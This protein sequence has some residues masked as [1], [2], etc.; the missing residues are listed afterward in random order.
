[1]AGHLGV[2]DPPISSRRIFCETPFRFSQKQTPRGLKTSAARL[3]LDEGQPSASGW[4]LQLGADMGRDFR[5]VVID[6][7]AKTMMRDAPEFRPV[8]QRANRRLFARGKN[9]A[10][11]QAGDVSELVLSWGD[12]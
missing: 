12:E 3:R 9:A 2:G 4:Y 5:G 8:A 7:V 6:E 1:M 10:E 11:T